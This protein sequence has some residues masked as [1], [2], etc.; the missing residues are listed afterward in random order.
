MNRYN[1]WEIVQK[2]QGLNTLK[3]I[4]SAL[5]VD[6]QKAIYLIHKL[7]IAGFVKTKYD[8]N[9]KRI[10]YI[11]P[12]N[13]LGGTS[14]T[15]FIN[16]H[17]PIKIMETDRHMI[18]GKDISVEDA[19]IYALNKKSVR[20]VIACLGLFRK[21]NNW[22]LLY[23]LAK[24]EDIFREIC[25]LYDIAR[26]ILPKIKKMPKRFKTLA[27][28][29]KSDKFKYIIKGFSSLHFKDIENKWKV[30]IPLNWGDLEDYKGAFS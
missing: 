30:Y 23:K 27:S 6:R 15:E 18:Y 20:Y 2:L 14:Y 16:K 22:S 9:K 8:S 5:S 7:R 26:K 4:E 13:A 3:M 12:K 25:A 19:F 17:S 24:K 28:P 10:Y 1:T 29:K 21:I 11:S